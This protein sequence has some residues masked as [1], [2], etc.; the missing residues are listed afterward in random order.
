MDCARF[1]HV[2]NSSRHLPS[3]QGPSKIR[4][5]AIQ[6]VDVLVIGGGVVG[7][8][9]ANE[10]QASGRNVTLIERGQ[11][12][13]AC[14]YANAGWLTPCFAMPLPQPGMF[15]KSVGWL[16]DSNSP[17]YIQPQ[18]NPTLFRWMWQFLRAMNQKRM[19]ESV[20]VL[21]AISTFSLDYY[22]QLS[23]R[24][25]RKMGF[26]THGL[27]M[28]SA[29]KAGL[30]AA[31]LEMQLMNQRGIAGRWLEQEELLKFEPSLK[32]IVQ[33]GVYFPDE[34]QA[35]PYEATLAIMDEFV[36]RGGRMISM[37]E[38]F[39]FD[40]RDGR[41]ARIHTTQ[42]DFEADLVVLASGSWSNEIAKKLDLAIPILG[43]KG[44]S[45]SVDMKQ[46]K[47]HHPIM[48]IE[49]KIAITPFEHSVRLAGTLE[50]VDQDFSISPNRVR[51]IHRG[52]QEYLHF[53]KPSEAG[54]NETGS[55]PLY[56]LS[57]VR[58][59]WRGLRPCTPDGVPVIGPSTK[60]RNLFYCAGHQLLGFQSAPGS[61]RLAADLIIGRT[62]LTDPWPFRA[63]RFE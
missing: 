46:N 33:G 35:N 47:P 60:L 48:I 14:S 4:R 3:A 38:A 26:D 21:T 16:L 23:T 30:G 51:G 36:E 29:T 31:N 6:K 56:D 49:R 7:A 25:K 55:A 45:M 44:Y 37:T 59:V 8:S 24:T 17:L 52:A 1:Q 41:I 28:V 32:P 61:G 12:G 19:M 50:L 40:V 42:G 15:W 22:R 39:D 53:D 20:A 9:V 62:P 2:E 18:V 54:K 27:L 5:M 13:Q 63:D 11:P 34:A 43:G 10:L 57:S 58:D